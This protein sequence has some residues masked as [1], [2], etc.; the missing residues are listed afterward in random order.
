MSRRIVVLV[1]PSAGSAERGQLERA[2]HAAGIRAELREAGPEQLWEAAVR[3]A[4]DA[5]IVAI[6]GGDGT[7]NAVVSAIGDR[8]VTL[9]IL[10]LGTLNHLARDLGVPDDLDGAVALLRDGPTRRIDVGEVNGRVFLNNSSIGLYP[11]AVRERDAAERRGASRWP[12]MA[13]ATVRALRRYPLLDVRIEAGETLR[14]CSTPLVF[15]GNNRYDLS[16]AGA[17]GRE[18]LDGGHLVIYAARDPG[19]MGLLRL[20]WWAVRGR[21][22]RHPEVEFASAAAATV[23]SRRPALDVAVD[24]EVM[25]L[26]TPLRYRIRPAAL[27]VVAPP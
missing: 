25:R 20:A 16:M 4:D 14:A 11:E 10:P 18:R 8:D 22:E 3:A 12:A 19:R 17:G 27:E 2:L 21:L 24:G 23:G 1:N 5:D 9:A 7:V 6:G 26:D 15:V 13:I